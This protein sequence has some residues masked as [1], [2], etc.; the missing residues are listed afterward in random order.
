MSIEGSEKSHL[1]YNCAYEG[2]FIHMGLLG[3]Y[4]HTGPNSL[5][6]DRRS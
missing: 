6:P 5:G 3:H 4:Q 1:I 2:P